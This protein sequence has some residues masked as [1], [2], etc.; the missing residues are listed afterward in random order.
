MIGHYYYSGTKSMA[1]NYKKAMY[2]FLLAAKGYPTHTPKNADNEEKANIR[3]QQIAASNSVGYLGQMYQRAEGTEKDLDIARQWFERGILQKNPSSYCG[4]GKMTMEGLGGLQQ[5]TTKA[6]EYLE[7][8]AKIG[9]S[10]A[11]VI[12]AQLQLGLP[13]TNT[14][15]SKP[16]F[17]IAYDHLVA[18]SQKGYPLSY[19]LLSKLHGTGY[20]SI[21]P[22]CKTALSVPTF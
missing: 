13:N 21:Q 22:D 15:S 2:Y 3:Q 20:A 5:D 11:H 12:L 17:K 14:D 8:A 19:Y 16:N 6:V 7:Q 4:M 10:E 18:A 9:N 1:P